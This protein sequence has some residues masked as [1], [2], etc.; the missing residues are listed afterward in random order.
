MTE[1]D[2]D[3][4]VYRQALERRI[5]ELEEE[6]ALGDPDKAT[7]TLDQ[8]SVGRLSRMDAMQRQAMAK[9]TSLRRQN[10]S[11]RLRAA[12]R[13]LDLGEFGYCVECGEQIAPA[14]LRFDPTATKCISCASG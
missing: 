6:S 14:R 8:Q 9:A 12:L 7:V 5:S 4:Q 13:R 2:P 3:M 11:K 10:E 1:T